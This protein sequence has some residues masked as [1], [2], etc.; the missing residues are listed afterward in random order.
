MDPTDIELIDWVDHTEFSGWHTADEYH[1]MPM[2]CRT[3]GWVLLENDLCITLVNTGPQDEEQDL[4][5]GAITIV[6]SS[7]T[8]RTKISGQ[9]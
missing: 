1:N 4:Y 2:L 9:F 6:K 8:K 7:I 5:I 3:V